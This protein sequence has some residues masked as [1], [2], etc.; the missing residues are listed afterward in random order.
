LDLSHPLFRPDRELTVLPR[1]V[2]AAASAIGTPAASPTA[3]VQQQLDAPA[4]DR[5]HPAHGSFD[6]A[7][8]AALWRWRRE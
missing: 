3:A 5:F 4:P 7:V 8:A 1:D 6:A 2:A